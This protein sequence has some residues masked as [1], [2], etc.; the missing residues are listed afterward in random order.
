MRFLIDEQLP[1]GLGKQLLDAGHFAEHVRDVGLG[2]ATD[3]AVRA[4]AQ[5]AGAVLVS[6]DDDFVETGRAGDIA[7]VWI[8]LG[9]VTNKALWRVLER[10]LP[11]IVTAIEGGETLIEVS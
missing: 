5:R 8:R 11:E 9:N 6:K 3:V 2:G 4:Y 1:P 10:V 7:V